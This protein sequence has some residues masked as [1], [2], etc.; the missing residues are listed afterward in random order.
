MKFKA[1][2][3]LKPNSN[4]KGILV[5]KTDTPPLRVG[6]IGSKVQRTGAQVTPGRVPPIRGRRGLKTRGFPRLQPPNP[7]F[8]GTFCAPDFMV[9]RTNQ[10]CAPG[11][12][13]TNYLQDKFK[14]QHTKKPKQNAP[15]NLQPATVNLQKA[16]SASPPIPLRYCVGLR[17]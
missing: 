3:F 6:L 8:G 7:R 1:L 13:S 4:P 15:V 9:S 12:F 2:Q 14:I 10:S 16:Q 5:L 17:P 11:V